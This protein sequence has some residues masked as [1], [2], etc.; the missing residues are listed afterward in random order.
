NGAVGR[1]LMECVIKRAQALSF[2]GIRLVQAA[3][4]NRSLSLYTKLGF[5]TLEPLSTLQGPALGLRVSGR[6]VRLAVEGDVAGCNRICQ[7]IHG[8]DRGQELLDA[9]RLKTATIV[10]H[11][12]RVT[13]YATMFSYFG[14]AVAESNEDLQ[15]LI[16]DASD[17]PGPGFIVPTRNS[18]LL[19]WC[20]N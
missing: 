3:Y 7:K 9:I 10:E 5:A 19:R 4:H 11:H 1:Q 13:G 12:G 14:H 2:S 17:F 8:H 16:G 15:A 20:L 18:D 6:T